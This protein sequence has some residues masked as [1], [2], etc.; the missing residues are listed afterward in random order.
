MFLAWPPPM[1]LQP[2]ADDSSFKITVDQFP[3]AASLLKLGTAFGCLLSM[4][5]VDLVGRKI[6][7]LFTYV[8]TF[9]CWLLVAWKP[10]ASNLCLARFMAGASSG[11]IFTSGTMYV[12]EISRPQI[13]GIL[14]GCFILMDY[15]G[16]LT[17]YA[18]ASFGTMHVFPYVA[19]SLATVQFTMFIWFPESP[20][21]LLQRKRF[22][23]AM[24]SLIFLRNSPDVSEEMD[25]IV[26]SVECDPRNNGV[27]S[28]VLH[29]ISQ[30]GGKSLILFG[31]CIMT[32]QA[33][34]SSIVLIG[35][36]QTIFEKTDVQMQ[37]SQMSIV[38]AMLHLTS[39]LVCISLVDSLGRRSL[40]IVSTVGV[41]YCSFL[42]GVYFCMEENTVYMTN[43]Q[44]LPFVV[45]LFYAVS[46]SLGLTY[47][48]FVIVNEIFPMYSRATC[49]SF[50]FCINFTWS[51]I[52][53]CI[54]SAV[55]FQHNMYIVFWFIS[56]LNAFSILLLVFY[57]PE[58]KRK[59]FLQI[60]NSIIGK[61][62]K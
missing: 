59:S 15:C 52:I 62:I 39:Y 23:A 60:Q 13:R 5:I 16:N 18:V 44:L 10:S 31:L 20:Y 29:L 11:I 6:S 41:A 53:L 8:P 46:V 34:S 19:M 48:P 12:T 35:Y 40:M 61:I 56:S 38:L 32:V 2:Q 30:S 51:F 37:G 57:L 17:G 42:L 21:Y 33:F 3:W 54:W 58:T 22:E 49:V 14:C 47:V 28:S 9:L 36:A 4:F 50:C 26:R 45:I 43:L 24:D 7:I 27:L 1:I 55:T 25:S